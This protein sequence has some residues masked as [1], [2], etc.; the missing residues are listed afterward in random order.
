MRIQDF[1]NTAEFLAT[2]NR[3]QLKEYA[4]NNAGNPYLVSLA[5]F[6]SDQQKAIDRS[7][8]AKAQP[9]ASVVDSA[10]ENIAPMARASM[11]AEE[12]EFDMPE[13]S[14][15]GQIPIDDTYFGAAGGII[16]FADGDLVGPEF[17]GSVTQMA[18]DRPKPPKPTRE[19]VNAIVQAL[20]D[21]KQAV[22]LSTVRDIE[23]GKI[24]APNK[25]PV[26][27]P[28]VID[29]PT[30]ASQV[31]PAATSSA[32]MR[33]TPMGAGL[34]SLKPM[35]IKAMFEE[36]KKDRAVTDS[37]F[38]SQFEGLARLEQEAAAAETA[39][40]EKLQEK[41][42]DITKGQRARQ[43]AKEKAIE[44]MDNQ[45]IGIG[46]LLFGA[47]LM[48]KRNPDAGVGI[49]GYLA[50][51]DKVAAARDKLSESRDRLEAAEAER[52]ILN[53]TE[54]NKLRANEKKVGIASQKVMLKAVMDTYQ[55]DKEEGL[56]IL[57]LRIKQGISLY[58]QDR[59]DRRTQMQI[60][61][62][63]KSPDQQIF[64][65]FLAQK[66][67]DPIEA[68][69]AYLKEF[70]ST[71]FA[72]MGRKVGLEAAYKA[73]TEALAS[74]LSSELQDKK[75]AALQK[76]IQTLSGAAPATKTAT[77]ADIEATA[78]AKGKTVQETLAAAKAQ[79]FV[80]Q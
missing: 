47:E 4:Q 49:K 38:K 57:D 34:P 44:A 21:N 22:G 61:A 63:D 58:E 24:T 28:K 66:G 10:I 36:A 50:N 40:L 65:R 53:A 45:G 79:G 5:L 59:Q 9:Q 39:G 69:K 73:Y 42:A 43:D 60:N 41:Y 68:K 19:Q 55:V 23:E 20:R 29:L 70:P 18:D 72:N 15:I 11:P 75:L 64:D 26:A 16:A 62:K 2:M 77:M 32:P 33:A 6:V 13:D 54:L 46:L 12:V 51:R 76:Q 78:K 3:D 25:P 74:P 48:S 37:P 30:A 31:S 80:V 52:G 1:S 67:G 7:K 35:D 8:Q 71:D 14:G 17:G 56:K 27:A